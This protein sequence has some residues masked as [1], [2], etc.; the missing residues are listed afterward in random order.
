MA[1]HLSLLTL[2]LV[3]ALVVLAVMGIAKLLS[4]EKARTI[5]KVLLVVPAVAL[6]L[7]VFTYHFR[8]RPRPFAWH[9]IETQKTATEAYAV[10]EDVSV[11]A[12]NTPGAPAEEGQEE[13]AAEAESK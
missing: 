5:L 9:S 10:V 7:G 8:S 11:A 2:V 13:G 4:S 1:V 3:A 12:P 6:L